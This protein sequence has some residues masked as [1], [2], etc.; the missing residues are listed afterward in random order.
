VIISHRNASV[1]TTKESS[2]C[3]RQSRRVRMGSSREGP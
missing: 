3:K 2:K 1:S